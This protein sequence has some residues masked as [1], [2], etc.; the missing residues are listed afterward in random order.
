MPGEKYY[1]CLN[2]KY[3]EWWCLAFAF[4]AHIKEL[5]IAN[6]KIKDLKI[7]IRTPHK[8]IGR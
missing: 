5:S 7:S 8:H 2:E 3:S 4:P 6:G 1:V